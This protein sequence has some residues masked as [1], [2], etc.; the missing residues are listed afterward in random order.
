M[1]HFALLVPDPDCESGPGYGSRDPIE[2]GSTRLHETHFFLKSNIRKFGQFC[3]GFYDPQN[4]EIR[5]LDFIYEV[6]RIIQKSLMGTYNCLG[7]IPSN[8]WI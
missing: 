8:Y 5:N 2:S 4:S 6:H 1:G 3:K 7:E